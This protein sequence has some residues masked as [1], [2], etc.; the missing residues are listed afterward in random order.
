[1][2]KYGM[3][4]RTTTTNSSICKCWIDYCKTRDE[5]D[6][7]VFESSL[8]RFVGSRADMRDDGR[9][10]ISYTSVIK[11][12]SGIKST[13]QKLSGTS[14]PQMPTL[15]PATNACKEWCDT[16]FRPRSRRIGFSGDVAKETFLYGMETPDIRELR[17]FAEFVFA[18]T[19][20]RLRDSSVYSFPTIHKV[21]NSDHLDVNLV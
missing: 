2:G 6:F 15:K 8:L 1:M 20:S 21:C 19:L 14:L 5:E 13:H 11:Y 12:I 18:Y 16:R 17:N 9:R 10:K 7:S 3:R 4:N